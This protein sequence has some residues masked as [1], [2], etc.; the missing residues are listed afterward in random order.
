MRFRSLCALVPGLAIGSMALTIG[1]PTA[2]P[3]PPP[4]PSTVAAFRARIQH[5]VFVIK[6]N[7]T[8]DHYFG[9]FP[10]ADGVTS[11]VISTGQRMPLRR[12]QDRMPHDIGHEWDDA[13]IATDNGRMDRFDLVTG[14]VDGSDILSM[15]QFLA[16]DIP[17]Y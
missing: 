3:P 8:F 5:I 2:A 10:G 4:S 14:A 6:E 13:H 9:T 7:R 1:C 15:T 16:A 17:N 12:A 11:G